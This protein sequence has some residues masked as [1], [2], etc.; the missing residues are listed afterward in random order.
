VTAAKNGTYARLRMR[1]TGHIKSEV[2]A[3][4]ATRPTHRSDRPGTRRQRCSAWAFGSDPSLPPANTQAQ[5]AMSIEG[6]APRSPL[7]DRAL[8]VGRVP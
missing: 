7:I 2:R 6:P 1:F 3:P 4:A 8:S 5:V